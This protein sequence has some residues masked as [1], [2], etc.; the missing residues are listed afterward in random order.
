[1][2]IEEKGKDDKPSFSTYSRIFK[3]M[4][5]GFHKPKKDQCC[6][7]MSFLKGTESQKEELRTRYTKHIAE[8]VKVRELKSSCKEIAQGEKVELCTIFDLQQVIHL[9]ISK[10]TLSSTSGG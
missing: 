8:K 9:R 10:R 4:N 2:F 1:M 7:C 6:L 5:F 3:H